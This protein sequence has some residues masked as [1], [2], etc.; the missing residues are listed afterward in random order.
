MA[1][2]LSLT[3]SEGAKL[4]MRLTMAVVGTRLNCEMSATMLNMA[5][6]LSGKLR[7]NSIVITISWSVLIVPHSIWIEEDMKML[8]TKFPNKI[9]FAEFF[10]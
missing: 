8:R 1:L 2:K 6:Q 4:N 9:V 5:M 10:R 3:G 7:L